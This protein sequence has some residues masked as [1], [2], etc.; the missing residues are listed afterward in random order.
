M[1]T[2]RAFAIS[3]ALSA[4]PVYAKSDALRII[5][6]YPAGGP[7]DAAARFIADKLT[8]AAGRVIVENRP[9]AAGA[10]GMQAA[11]NAKPDGKTLVV[12]ALATLAVNPFMQKGL[13]YQAA[14]FTPIALLS[15][16]PNVLVMNPSRMKTLGITDAASLLSYIKAHPG[17][18]NFAS[19]GVGSAGHLAGEILRHAGY[20]LEHIPYAGAAAAQLSIFSGETDLLFDNWGSTREAVQ[21]GKLKA[22]AVTTAKPYP[23]LSIPTLQSLGI[24]CDL[25]T[26]FG[27]LAPKGTG[28]TSVE[29]LYRSLAEIFKDPKEQQTFERLAG[30]FDLQGPQTF[31]RWIDKE[32]VKYATLLKQ[33]N[34]KSA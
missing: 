2:R 21:S 29:N 25:S 10:R 19:G 8:S 18:L 3:L 16:A 20:G 7:L 24:D 17:K 1:L 12:G 14:D 23:A 15:D 5:V 28:N 11:K 27:L 30:G 9:G 13:P 6:P 26:W 32:Q 22:L 31:G 4:L 34:L 33:L